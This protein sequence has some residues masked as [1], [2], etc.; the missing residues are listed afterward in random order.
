VAGTI[1]SLAA[2]AEEAVA[3]VLY[4]RHGHKY[5]VPVIEWDAL[6]DQFREPWLEDARCAI[7]AAMP[8]LTQGND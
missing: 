7:E 6:E 8:Y 2:D 1:P 3:R 5:Y 4:A